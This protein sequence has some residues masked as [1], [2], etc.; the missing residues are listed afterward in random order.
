MIEQRLI[1]LLMLLVVVIAPCAMKLTLKVKSLDV[2]AH[3]KL[4]Q[5]QFTLLKREPTNISR[6]QVQIILQANFKSYCV[7]LYNG[8]IFDGIIK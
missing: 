7:G 3:F 8:L 4:H 2:I 1:S 6:K 5:E